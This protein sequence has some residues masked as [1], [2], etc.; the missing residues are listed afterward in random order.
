[1]KSES[2]ITLI[3]WASFGLLLLACFHFGWFLFESHYYFVISGLILAGIWLIDLFFTMPL[4]PLKSGVIKW[5]RTDIGTFLMIVFLSILGVFML[6]WLHISLNILLMISATAL[7]R[8]ELQTA[9]FN[10]WHA[11]LILSL[12]ST[13]GLMLGWG[14]N[15]YFSVDYLEAGFCFSFDL[16]CIEIPH[17]SETLPNHESNN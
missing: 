7:A 5:I 6:T 3:T 12:L 1:M 10:N 4:N 14:L 13:V 8:L 16:G 2:Q 17:S 15:Y 11:F 9:R